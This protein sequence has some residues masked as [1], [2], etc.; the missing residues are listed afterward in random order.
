[1]RI[2]TPLEEFKIR[3]V[4][5][6]NV[7]NVWEL[8]IKEIEVIEWLILLIIM[9]NKR[10]YNNKIY[11]NGILIYKMIEVNILKNINLYKEKTGIIVLTVMIYILIGNI[12][13]LIPWSSI[14]TLDILVNWIISMSIIIW[15]TYI[16]IRQN[17]Q[18]SKYIIIIKNIPLLISVMMTLIEIISYMSRSVSLTIRL[19]SN[20]LGSLVLVKLICSIIN[21]IVETN[22]SSLISIILVITICIYIL[23]IIVAFV[24][25][26]IYSILTTIYLESTVSLH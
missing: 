11:N 17:K 19:S 12:L 20:I 5:T 23:E 7:L 21:L 26:Y 15:I 16:S 4:L 8:S 22:W 14:I 10:I 2:F 9:S 13:G 3:E 1:M 6:I 25:S 24:Q 18:K